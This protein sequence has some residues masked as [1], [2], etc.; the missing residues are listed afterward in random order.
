MKKGSTSE[1][2]EAVVEV[3]E[4]ASKLSIDPKKAKEKK[5]SSRKSSKY[6]NVE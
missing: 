4:E 3:E 5:A 1:K 2:L 6:V